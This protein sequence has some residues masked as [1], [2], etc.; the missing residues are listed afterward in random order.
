MSYFVLRT[1]EWKRYLP[2]QILAVK[3]S[4]NDIGLEHL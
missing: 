4:L 1:L 3:L 2:V